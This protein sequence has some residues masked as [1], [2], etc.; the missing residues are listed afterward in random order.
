MTYGFIIL[1]HVNSELTNQYWNECVQCIRKLYPYKKI[2]VI[3]DNSNKK[4][5]KA[6]KEYHNIEYIK[7]EFPQ[8]GELLPY[9][10]FHKHKFFDNAIIIHDSVFIYKRIN[11]DFLSNMR[12]LPLWHFTHARDENYE[13]I[14]H[15]SKQ[16]NNYM[17]LHNH[18]EKV[19]QNKF[20]SM[21][22]S[23]NKYWN[24]C[25]GVQTYI[26][27]SFLDYLQKKY[28]IFNM[29][30]VVRTRAD[31][32]CLERIMGLISYIENPILIK[33]PSLLGNIVNYKNDDYKWGYTF[34]QYKNYLQNKHRVPVPFVKVW[35]GR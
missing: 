2:V 28:N 26:N 21:G 29:L 10:Y 4:F 18:F 22:I 15:I 1:R 19:N 32:C 3:D 8:R 6:E 16:L 11:F 9:Y 34:Q 20:V 31:R 7:S 5:V 30:K 35:T 17:K 24:G 14:L 12:I 25:F 27:H 33:I 23:D 13:Q